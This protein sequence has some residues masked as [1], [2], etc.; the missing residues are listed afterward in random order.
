[1]LSFEI[2]HLSSTT[3][4]VEVICRLRDFFRHLVS[5]WARS[6]VINR[7]FVAWTLHKC[8]WIIVILVWPSDYN[9]YCFLDV[10]LEQKAV[11]N[12]IF[13][14]LRC[15]RADKKLI[16]AWNML[17]LLLQYLQTVS[18]FSITSRGPQIRLLNLSNNTSSPTLSLPNFSTSV[19]ETVICR[20]NS[21]LYVVCIGRNALCAVVDEL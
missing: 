7:N 11:F 16:C 15:W 2:S 20:Q 10:R 12:A 17:R 6:S 21:R 9:I 13:L 5:S 8:W 4:V 19:V 18:I 14:K 1:M 3:S